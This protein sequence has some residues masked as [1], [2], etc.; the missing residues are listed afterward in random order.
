MYKGTH[1]CIPAL[2]QTLFTN[3]R[4]VLDEHEVWKV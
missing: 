4:L 3:E 1:H 2:S